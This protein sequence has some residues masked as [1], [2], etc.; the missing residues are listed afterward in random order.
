MLVSFSN[1]FE[2]NPSGLDGC[3]LCSCC[4]NVQ[5]NSISANLLIMAWVFFYSFVILFLPISPMFICHVTFV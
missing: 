3:F 1:K 2:N 5:V 4:W